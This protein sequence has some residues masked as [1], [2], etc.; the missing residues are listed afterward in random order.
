MPYLET[1]TDIEINALVNLLAQ[2]AIQ[3]II[4]ERSIIRQVQSANK[5]P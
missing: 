3:L 1:E 4:L 2:F 5:Q